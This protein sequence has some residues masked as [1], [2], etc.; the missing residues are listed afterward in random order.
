MA[1]TPNGL[2]APN[3]F[4]E[5]S[6]LHCRSPHILTHTHRPRRPLQLIAAEHN[7]PRLC[8]RDVQEDVR[9]LRR[10]AAVDEDPGDVLHLDDRRVR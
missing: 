10:P 1:L 5:L 7:I 9:P 3:L 6:F 4:S 8:A 2:F